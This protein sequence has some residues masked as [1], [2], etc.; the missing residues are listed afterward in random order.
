MTRFLDLEHWPRRAAWEFFRGYDNPYFNVC[1]PLEVTSLIEFS[2]STEDVPFSLAALHLA[3]RAANECEPFRYRIQDGKVIVHDHIHAGTT[4]LLEGELLAFVYYDYHED[5]ATF[6]LGAAR[7]KEA[8]GNHAIAIDARADRT[9]LIHFSSLPWVAFTSI[10]HARNWGREDSVPKITFGRYHR[11]GDRIEIP[12][13]VEVHHALLDGVHVGRY[14]ERL[15][16][17]FAEPEALLRNSDDR[18]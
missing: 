6:R 18:S 16:H 17:Y 12:V 9:D 5:F 7:A 15:Q 4:A 10:S 3:L 13:S 2:R 11:V 14:F 8:L 1:A